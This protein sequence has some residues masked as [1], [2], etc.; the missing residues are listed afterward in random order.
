MTDQEQK[1]KQVELHEYRLTWYSLSDCTN[2]DYIIAEN[3]E[4]AI[5]ILLHLHPDSIDRVWES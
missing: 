5:E 3:R 2:T 1:T 4:Q